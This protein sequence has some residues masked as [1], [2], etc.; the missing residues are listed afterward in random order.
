MRSLTRAASYSGA[1]TQLDLRDVQGKNKPMRIRSGE[2]VERVELELRNFQV[3]FITGEIMTLMDPKT[4]EQSE[5][6]VSLAGD[7]QPFLATLETV[8]L[9][10]YRDTPVR[11]VP[12]K[13]VRGTV[14]SLKVGHFE[15]HW[16]TATLT[17]GI[18]VDVPGI[19]K[20]GDV[21]D[22]RTDTMAFVA[23]A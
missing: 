6:P 2:R 8:T 3:L 12:P 21:I 11:L 4:F 9:E 1:L 23:K 15:T 17:N 14:Q 10:Y 22:L 16:Q 19:I 7:L 5:V 13:T 18:K 20:E